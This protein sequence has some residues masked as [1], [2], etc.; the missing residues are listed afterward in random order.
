MQSFAQLAPVFLGPSP[1]ASV[2]GVK[3][4][5]Y[6]LL[7][8]TRVRR[9]LERVSLA[10]NLYDGWRRPHPFDR[11]FGT[12]TSGVVSLADLR[13]ETPGD[14]F[15]EDSMHQYSG[16]QPSIVRRALQSLPDMTGFTFV[17]QGCGK[18][19]PLLVASEFPFR[20]I[21]GVDLSEGLLKIARSNADAI[22][23][24]FPGRTRIT[25]TQ[26]LAHHLIPQN[27]RVVFFQYNS[28]LH[29]GVS[30]FLQRLE[31]KLANPASDVFFVYYNPV[32]GDLFD[33]SPKLSRW[34]AASLPYDRAELGF[35]PDIEDSV[36][37][38]QGVPN[39][40]PARPGAHRRIIVVDP[41]YR[42]DVEKSAS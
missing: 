2:N 38:W 22:R 37:I 23:Q 10:K 31:D 20:E 39:R 13:R 1:C 7:H 9:V 19:R 17:D 40:R 34:F 42:A 41:R 24:R 30:E 5:L 21:I 12:D 32:C 4:A 15:R 33:N 14:Q 8:R 27:D 6:W 18:G 36:V 26:G 29:S 28:F 25:L 11:E 16:S 35:G 3:H